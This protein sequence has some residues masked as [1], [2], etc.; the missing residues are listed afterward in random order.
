MTKVKRP[1][2]IKFGVEELMGLV[3]LFNISADGQKAIRGVL[4]REPSAPNACLFRYY[5]EHSRVAELEKAFAAHMKCRYALGVNS[6]TSALIAAMVAAGVGPGTEVIVPGY[7]F[8]AS[9]SAVVVA[10]GIPVIVEIDESLTLDPAAVER[11]I[12][13]R[14]KAI[15][16]VHMAGY[17]ARM[18]ALR[19]IADR[20]NVYLIED[21][22]QAAGG[23]Y[24]GRRLGTWGHLGCF[25]F[26]AYKVMA[27]G[28]GG[29]I[30]TE[31]EW[32][33][34]RAQ[35]YHDTAAGGRPD[36]Y[37][38]ER[39]PGELFCGENYRMS[40]MSGAIGLAQLRRL[41]GINKGTLRAYNQFRKE[42][43]L[44]AGVRWIEPA[45]P[46]G[47]CGY[48]AALIFDNFE[49]ARKAITANIGVGGLAGGGARG[50]RDW[51]VYW[52]WEH[53]LEQKTATQE[54]CPFK[55]PHVKKA[56]E[57]SPD[58]CPRTKDIMM[59]VALVGL[60]PADTPEYVSQMAAEFTANLAKAI[61]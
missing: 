30:T 7:T 15:V 36:R 8:F 48:A 47:L 3:G 43:V 40:E 11:A 22:A 29:M 56:P 50:A 60:S 27:T 31:D 61:A 58:M 34:T 14:T 52:Y 49:L 38:R 18:D 10:K 57:Y 26:D 55:C 41:D 5:N 51:H 19:E 12:T 20:H 59:R 35:S 9:A 42:T 33:Y 45:D 13:P 28:E 2:H 6:G 4:A 21:V 46:E 37:G 17:P 16:V 44:P 54:G 39:K 24:K 32:L 53:V 1:D 23:T 25:S